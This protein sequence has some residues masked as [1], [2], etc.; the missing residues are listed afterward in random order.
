MDGVVVGKGCK[1]T[2]CILGKRCVIGD[3]SILTDCEVQENLLVEP[4][5]AYLGFLSMRSPI[6]FMY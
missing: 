4:Q 3:G 1:L 6:C 2:R 5:S